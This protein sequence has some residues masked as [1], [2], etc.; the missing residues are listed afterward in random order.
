VQSLR[1]QQSTSYYPHA[2]AE[3]DFRSRRAKYIIY[4]HTHFAEC[5]PLEASHAE[6]YVLNQLYFN[7]GTWRRTLR[8]TMSAPNEHEFVPVDTMT[9]LAFFQGDERFGRPY[10][11]W[12]GTLGVAP[13]DMPALRVDAGRTADQAAAAPVSAHELAPHFNLA[14]ATRRLVPTRRK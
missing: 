3:S 12:S 7:S 13:T 9:Y 10:E 2:L 11:T 6:G 4:G 1:G 8:P 14:A 5:V